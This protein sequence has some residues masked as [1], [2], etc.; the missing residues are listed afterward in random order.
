MISLFLSSHS[1]LLF[2]SSS[3]LLSYPLLSYLLPSYPLLSYLLLPP[4]ASFLRLLVYASTYQ[5]ITDTPLGTR[6]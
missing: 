6:S 3:L 2:V 1:L 5:P 4:S